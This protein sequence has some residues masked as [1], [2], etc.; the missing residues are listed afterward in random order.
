MQ[1][2]SPDTSALAVLTVTFNPDIARLSLQIASLP[3][4]A[5]LIVV[6]NASNPGTLSSLQELLNTRPHTT[7]IKNQ[8]NLGLATA[9]NQAANH[10]ITQQPSA[11]YLLLMDQDS[12][13]EQGAI[14]GLLAAHIE[15]EAQGLKV[16][17][18]GPRLI[19]NTTG[20]QHGFHQIKGWRWTRSYPTPDS[21]APIYCTNLN[22]SGT[23]M[24][25]TLMQTLGG[26]D[27]AFFIDHID[28]EWAFRV[29]SQGWMLY[30]IP[31][32][33]FDHCM[34]E[35]SLRFW[36]LGWRIWPQRSPQR[37][38]YLYRNALWLMRR[39]YVPRVWKTWALAKL[40]L[41]MLVHTIGDLQRR[42]QLREMLAGLNAGL[43]YR[44]KND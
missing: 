30:G 36:F 44:P 3:L 32:V 14:T 1:H 33:T 27:E 21:C 29:L 24:R 26:L 19:D 35:R 9:L 11:K 8:T 17:C 7:L 6:D 25:T 39:N 31:W 28:T 10:A 43:N 37:H 4:D 2:T 5:S 23:L 18:V 34:G 16:G 38:Y 20:L 40:L 41:T 22:G 42:E 13:P 12:V 15:L